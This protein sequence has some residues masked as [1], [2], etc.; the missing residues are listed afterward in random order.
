VE[1]KEGVACRACKRQ[2]QTLVVA[3]SDHKR[4]LAG[5]RARHAAV[6]IPDNT[7][8]RFAARRVTDVAVQDD[9]VDEPQRRGF[10]HAR[11]GLVRARSL[12]NVRDKGRGKRVDRAHTRAGHEAHD[13]RQPRRLVAD[14]VKNARGQRQARQVDRVQPRRRVGGGVDVA[15]GGASGHVGERARRRAPVHRRRGRR[16]GRRPA[17]GHGVRRRAEVDVKL[18]RAVGRN[19]EVRPPGRLGIAAR[20]LEHA[21]RIV[22][23]ADHGRQLRARQR[24]QREKHGHARGGCHGACGL[25]KDAAQFILRTSLRRGGVRRAAGAQI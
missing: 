12:A 4:D 19:L 16:G 9:R 1:R 13:G 22:R 5:Q 8:L 11:D 6:G 23:V 15:V 17:D 2:K 10:E 24:E 25:Y 20:V 18:L 3:K 21:R 7:T 14:L